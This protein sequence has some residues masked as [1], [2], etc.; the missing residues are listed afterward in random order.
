MRKVP[1]VSGLGFAF[2]DIKHMPKYDE[3][4]KEFKDRRTKWNDL[5]S[6][7]FFNGAEKL[8]LK[9]KD[10]VDKDAAFRAIKTIMASWEPK[11]EH[12]EA[13]CAYL[14]SEWF[15][16]YELTEKARK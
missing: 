16:D 8:E 1:E 9:P 6:K 11:H 13:A 10:G 7:L 14:F 2:G 4:P 15:T 3:I 5:F 12:K